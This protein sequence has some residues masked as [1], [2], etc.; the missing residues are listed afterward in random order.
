MNQQFR[1]PSIP[2]WAPWFWFLI[3]GYGAYSLTTDG[4]SW[5]TAAGTV[6]TACTGLAMRH[7]RKA[8]AFSRA[9][10]GFNP[11]SQAAEKQ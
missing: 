3:A 5:G 4:W 2:A 7:F 1:Y 8:A 9:N 6:V 10:P 11:I